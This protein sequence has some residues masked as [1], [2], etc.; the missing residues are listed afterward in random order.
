MSETEYLYS[1]H[2]QDKNKNM[3]IRWDNSPHHK[4]LKT[5]P[6]H[7]HVPEIKESNE[8]RIEDILKVIEE[9]IK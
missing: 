1:Y 8:I 3:I 6:H 9:K 2:W 7:K 4:Q 5:F